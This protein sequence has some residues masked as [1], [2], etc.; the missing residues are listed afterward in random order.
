MVSFSSL[1]FRRMDPRLYLISLAIILI[2]FVFMFMTGFDFDI[3]GNTTNYYIFSIVIPL[4]IVMTVT[5]F[6]KRAMN[7]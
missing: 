3:R 5:R 2:Y 6:M 4:G 1:M 7:W